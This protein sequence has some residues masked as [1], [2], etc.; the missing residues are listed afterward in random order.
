[1]KEIVMKMNYFQYQKQ[2][3]ESEKFILLIFQNML[4]CEYD[5]MIWCDFTTQLND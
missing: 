1:M 2:P 5:M 4:Q 3:Q